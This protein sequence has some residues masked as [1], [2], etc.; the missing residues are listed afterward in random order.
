MNA[1]DLVSIMKDNAT[2]HRA[3]AAIDVAVEARSLYSRFG[4]HR[5]ERLY[6][7][8]GSL[9]TKYT[10]ASSCTRQLA[11]SRIRLPAV[12]VCVVIMSSR[13]CRYAG[14]A[15]LTFQQLYDVY[16]VELAVTG[17][18]LSRCS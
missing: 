14:V 18:N 10:N 12:P 11:A 16:G 17:T 5:G 15:D 4:L 7:H 1:A 8:L 6:E 9:L 3:T 2:G 13:A